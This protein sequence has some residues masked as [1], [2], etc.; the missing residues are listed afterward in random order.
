MPKK[1]VLVGKRKV[2]SHQN[3]NSCIK[4]LCKAIKI[5]SIKVLASINQVKV[6]TIL[7]ALK[8]KELTNLEVC[9]KKVIYL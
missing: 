1:V 8:L 6:L 5:Y 7:K 2:F 9:K 3:S 4:I